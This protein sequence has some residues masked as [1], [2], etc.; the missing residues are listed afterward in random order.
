MV[1]DRYHS[2]IINA[3]GLDFIEMLQKSRQMIV[4]ASWRECARYAEN[5]NF[6]AVEQFA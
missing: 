4:M 5:D 2:H 6:L 3:L 1:I